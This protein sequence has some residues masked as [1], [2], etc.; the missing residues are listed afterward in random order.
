MSTPA[1]RALTAAGIPFTERAYE[2]DPRAASFGREAADALGVEPERVFKTLLAEVDGRLVV[3]IVPVSTKLDLKA[4]AA[5]VGGRKAAMADPELAQKR[6]GYVVGGISPIGQKNRHDTVLDDSA[7]LWETV[8]VSGGRR[9]LDLE[10][11]P[12]DLL[13][14]TGGALADIAR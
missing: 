10:L 12:A 8:L 3:G 2:H 9:G 7:E 6:T 5:A 14:I 1:I 11:A 13:T 4:L